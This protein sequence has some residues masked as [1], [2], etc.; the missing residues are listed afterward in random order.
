MAWLH[1]L[2]DKSFMT[3][4]SVSLVRYSL[5][6]SVPSRIIFTFLLLRKGRLFSAM[7]CFF[8][9]PTT[10]LKALS[11]GGDRYGT[12]FF[13][14]AA[15][16]L[17]STKNNA[18]T[19]FLQYPTARF[20]SKVRQTMPLRISRR[21]SVSFSVTPHCFA[22]CSRFCQSRGYFL[23]S[24]MFSLCCCPKP[25]QTQSTAYFTFV[26]TTCYRLH[27]GIT[28]V[29]ITPAEFISLEPITGHILVDVALKGP[30]SLPRPS[31]LADNSAARVVR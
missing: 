22:R 2:F 5:S 17:H 8:R 3:T 10:P 19:H 16:L 31:R 26:Q 11:R 29:T 12:D 30:R 21:R 4:N 18:W 14:C 20:R 7:I 24:L 23:Q 13:S 28:T 1:V 6:K 27:V 9:N 25:N 15:C